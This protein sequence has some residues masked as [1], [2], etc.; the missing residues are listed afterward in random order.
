MNLAWEICEAFML[1]GFLPPL[2][3]CDL[4]GMAGR[5]ASAKDRWIIA[6]CLKSCVIAVRWAQATAKRVRAVRRGA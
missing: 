2:H 4:P 6:G 1:L 3:F 5:G